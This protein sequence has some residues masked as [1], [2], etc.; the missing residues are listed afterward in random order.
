MTR[1]V[2]GACLAMLPAL[3]GCSDPR[4]SGGQE[5]DPRG[6]SCPTPVVTDL[7]IPFRGA[8]TAFF[9][10]SGGEVWIGVSELGDSLFGKVTQTGVDIGPGPHPPEV[11]RVSNRVSGAVRSVTVHD[12]RLTLV[13]LPAGSYWLVSSNGGRI[14]LRTCPGVT[15]SEVSPADGEPGVAFSSG[16]SSDSP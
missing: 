5:D 12:D 11:D 1:L 6:A 16:V 4:G 10:T 8:R 2:L 14:E 13:D 9:R 3:G 15:I 7:G